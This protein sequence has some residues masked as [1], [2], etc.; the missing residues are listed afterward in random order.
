MKRGIETCQVT[1]SEDNTDSSIRDLITYAE[2]NNLITTYR[3]VDTQTS[4]R[5]TDQDQYRPRSFSSFYS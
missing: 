1:Y 4:Q 3:L 5:V 2:A